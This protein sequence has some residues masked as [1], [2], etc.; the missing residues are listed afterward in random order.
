MCLPTE[1][2]AS[3]G[4]VMTD[5]WSGKSQGKFFFNVSE[6]SVNFVRNQ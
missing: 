4:T 6:K 2:E 1:R 5:Q 3:K